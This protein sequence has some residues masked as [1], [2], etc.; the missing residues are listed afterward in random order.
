MPHCPCA[1]RL[2]AAYR[3]GTA[4]RCQSSA[5]SS[6]V[7]CWTWRGCNVTLAV[8]K[9]EY[10][11]ATTSISSAEL[12]RVATPF[13][14][15]VN[16]LRVAASCVLPKPLRVQGRYTHRK[17]QPS[18]RI[19]VSKTGAVISFKR[20]Q[21]SP[22]GSRMGCIRSGRMHALRRKTECGFTLARFLTH[23]PTEA[24][25][26]RSQDLAARRLRQMSN[27]LQRSPWQN[28]MGLL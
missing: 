1:R 26:N 20:V 15:R 8:W 5:I 6:H 28:A 16:A 19:M 21:F 24:Q 25:R 11:L 17:C 27:A 18:W 4:I 2:P 14:A 12:K 23:W 22:A 3:K 10:F 9:P 7:Y 13:R